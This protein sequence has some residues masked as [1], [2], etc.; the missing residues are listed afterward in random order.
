M[1]RPDGATSISHGATS[2]LRRTYMVPNWCPVAKLSLASRASCEFSEHASITVPS[3]LS[4]MLPF[5]STPSPAGRLITPT[6]PSW[7]C[8]Q[9]LAEDATVFPSALADRP[10]TGMSGRLSSAP[11]AGQGRLMRPRGQTEPVQPGGAATLRPLGCHGDQPTVPSQ[12][13]TADAP[14]PGWID[15]VPARPAIRPRWC[16]TQLRLRPLPPRQLA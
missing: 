10:F 12:P 11:S 3:A 8:D 15:G 9:G 1:Y 2:T 6:I 14:P 13:R 5:T 4:A 16:R 7:R